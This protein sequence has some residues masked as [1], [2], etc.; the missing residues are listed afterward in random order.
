MQETTEPNHVKH[1]IAWA[2]VKA[3]RALVY[4]AKSGGMRQQAR[5]VHGAS[6]WHNK[7]SNFKVQLH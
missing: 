2:V 7:S 6:A 4:C 1:D 3:A 5:E